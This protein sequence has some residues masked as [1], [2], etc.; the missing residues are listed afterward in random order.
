MRGRP[1][2]DLKA[3]WAWSRRIGGD[4]ASKQNATGRGNRGK[5]MPK[6]QKIRGPD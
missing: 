2:K 3:D 1:R 5:F 6:G 4:T